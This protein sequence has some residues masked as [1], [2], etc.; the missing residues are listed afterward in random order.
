MASGIPPRDVAKNI[1]VS[2]PT[3]YRW[4][5]ATDVIDLLFFVLRTPRQKT[6]DHSIQQNNPYATLPAVRSGLVGGAVACPGFF[7]DARKKEKNECPFFQARSFCLFSYFQRV[8][9]VTR[10][11]LLKGPLY[12]LL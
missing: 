10:H 3:L 1:G 12:L 8:A 6:V 11:F 5:P 4:L 7:A 2:I 9:S